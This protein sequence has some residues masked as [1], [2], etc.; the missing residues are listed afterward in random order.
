MLESFYLVKDSPH[1]GHRL[2]LVAVSAQSEHRVPPQC[3]HLIE[4]SER[5][6]I[7]LHA[8]HFAIVSP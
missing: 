6:M 7:A 2:F 3:L 5:A 1:A 8:T 4:L